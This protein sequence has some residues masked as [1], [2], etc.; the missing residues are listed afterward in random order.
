MKKIGEYT[1]RGIGEEADPIK[2][3]LFD[4]KFNTGYRITSFQVF[5]SNIDGQY[6][7][8]CT[9]K[10][11]TTADLNQNA[12]GFWNAGEPREIAWASSNDGAIDAGGILE[13]VID[14][15]NMII[16]DLYVYLRSNQ[17]EPVNYIVTMEKYDITDWQGALGM[18]RN[19]SQG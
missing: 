10:L 6:D 8:R 3:N 18:V 11:G 19:R 9:G 7:Q 15:D 1:V 13:S 16:E 4:G 14:P 12:V 2:I 17:N 5:A